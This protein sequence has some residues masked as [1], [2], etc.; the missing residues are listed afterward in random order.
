MDPQLSFFWQKTYSILSS[1]F[2]Q[3]L[4]KRC[5]VCGSVFDQAG[6]GVIL[7]PACSWELRPRT[8]GFCGLCA[9]IYALEDEST[10]LCLSCRTKP[11]SWQGISF[12]SVYNGLLKEMIIRY[13]FR[14]DL[15]L[16]N[17]LGNLLFSATSFHPYEYLDLIVPV[18]LHRAKLA[19]RG[20]N[21]SQELSRILAGRIRLPWSKD[22]LVKTR[23][24]PPQSALDRKHR[25]KAQKGAFQAGKEKV[26]DKKILLVDDI[27]TTG[28]TLE[29]CTRVL[30]GSG[31]SQ[32]RVVV[33]AR[34]V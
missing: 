25:L 18:P 20:F 13:K 3:V 4:G 30:L 9:R 26:K 12:Y 23:N 32:V 29:E 31:A 21:Q 2:R 28:S 34:A 27:M 1:G 22:A 16:G 24:T 14:A 6:P 11:F 7:C 5:S 17:V 8:G 15:G 33:L 10:H 19:S